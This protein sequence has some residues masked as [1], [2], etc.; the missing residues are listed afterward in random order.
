[1]GEHVVS[2]RGISAG[3]RGTD[4]NYLLELVGRLF[5]KTRGKET[6][7]IRKLNFKMENRP[8][9]PALWEARPCELPITRSGV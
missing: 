1:M 7:R 2:L 8:V 9:I 5:I 6:K 3:N 4:V